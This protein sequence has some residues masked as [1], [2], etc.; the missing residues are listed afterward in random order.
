MNQSIQQGVLILFLVEHNSVSY[1]KENKKLTA[2]T[3]PI[4]LIY[5]FSPRT[6][7]K[8]NKASGIQIY[9]LYKSSNFN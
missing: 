4:K 1:A 9:L 7:K 6:I 2:Y 8:L 5:F 3:D